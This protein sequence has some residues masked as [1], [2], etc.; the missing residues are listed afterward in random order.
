MIFSILFYHT[1]KRKVSIDIVMISTHLF[2]VPPFNFRSNSPI[3]RLI[4]C[5]CYMLYSILFYH[6]EKCEVS[7]DIVMFSIRLFIVPP[8][9]FHSNSPISQE[10]L[11]LFERYGSKNLYFI[12][13]FD[14]PFHLEFL[15]LLNLQK[16]WLFS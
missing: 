13:V 10:L 2:T 4:S 8:F 15:R 12:F 9:N 16:S 1:D 3:L 6:S 7:I 5:K 14:L 11:F